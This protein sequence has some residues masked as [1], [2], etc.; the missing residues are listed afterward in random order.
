MFFRKLRE[1]VASLDRRLAELEKSW[2]RRTIDKPVVENIMQAH[3]RDLVAKMYG[4]AKMYGCGYSQHS[5][6]DKRW[7]TCEPV[8]KYGHEYIPPHYPA[9]RR[10][11]EPL[12]YRWGKPTA[13]QMIKRLRDRESV[14]VSKGDAG[15]A[16]LLAA[17]RECIE[18]MRLSEIARYGT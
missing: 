15:D 4:F 12:K 6:S 1:T 14:L 7:D 9:S 3:T 5:D 13:Q 16:W 2:Y 11:G 18:D 8:N 10:A 17:A